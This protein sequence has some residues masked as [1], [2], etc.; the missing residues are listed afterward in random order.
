MGKGLGSGNSR[1]LIRFSRKNK[2]DYR[3]LYGF[4]PQH[5]G[6]GHLRCG[7]AEPGRR[8]KIR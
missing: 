8:A 2:L 1:K 5:G 7:G 4:A 3:R 6:F